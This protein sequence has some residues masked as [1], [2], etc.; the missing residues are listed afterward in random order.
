MTRNYS[1]PIVGVF[2]NVEWYYEQSILLELK[3][4]SDIVNLP[5]GV[6]AADPFSRYFRQMGMNGRGAEDATAVTEN[7]KAAVGLSGGRSF[8]RPTWWSDLNSC[9]A[10]V[11]IMDNVEGRHDRRIEWQVRNSDASDAPVLIIINDT[12]PSGEAKRMF[13]K[14]PELDEL[15][16]ACGIDASVFQ[17]HP[18]KIVLCAYEFPKPKK[19]EEEEESKGKSKSKSVSTNPPKVEEIEMVQ[20]PEILEALK[21]LSQNLIADSYVAAQKAREEAELEKKKKEEQAEQE[22]KEKEE[23]AKSKAKSDVP[24]AHIS[25]EQSVKSKTALAA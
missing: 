1:G 6:L 16:K 14:T 9:G 23:Q 25:S 18:V 5:A 15:C 21:W 20:P 11:F 17:T 12:T 24:V 4:A 19:A 3:N 10:Y 8:R 22:R 2:K 7:I 13:Q